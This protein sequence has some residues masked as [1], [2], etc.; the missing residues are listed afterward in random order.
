MLTAYS[1]DM[2]C[3]HAQV[4]GRGPFHGS[5][6]A[7]TMKRISYGAVPIPKKL[8]PAAG[9]FI[10]DALTWQAEARPCLADLFEHEWITEHAAG[11]PQSPQQHPADSTRVR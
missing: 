2:H 1:T 9:R 11:K 4:V 10:K 7:S 6:T 3:L 5:T 8:S